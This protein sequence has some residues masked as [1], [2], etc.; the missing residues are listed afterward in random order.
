MGKY[1][2]LISDKFDAH[3]IERLKKE[4]KLFEII[5]ENGHNRE[6]F[7]Q[8]LPKA[9]GLIV[10]SATKV[11]TLALEV[12][13]NLK[14]IIRAGVGVDNID[15]VAAS[16]KGIIVE[17]APGGNSIS[18]AEQALALLFSCARHIPRADASIKAG[19]WEKNKF[20]GI[21]ITGKTLGIV[22]LGRIGKEVLNRALGLKM[23][24]VGFDPFIPQEKLAH[25]QIELVS[26]ERLLE[27][28]DFITVHTP[29]TDTTKD[30]INKKNL[31]ILKKGVIL[32]NAA[33]G[34]IYN[35][36]ALVEGLEKKII[37]AV[38]L[39]VFIEEP[40]PE[41]SKLRKFENCVMTPHLGASTE[42][43]EYAVAMETVDAMT[44]YFKNGVARNSLNFPTIDSESMEFL[45][46]Y[47]EGGI[48]IGKFLGNLVQDISNIQIN[49]FGEITQFRTEAVTIALQYGVLSVAM[50]DE[51]NLVNASLLAQSRGIQTQIS[52]NSAAKGFSCYVQI[53]LNNTRGQN[54]E[55]KYTVM[56]NQALIFSLF[57]LA[58]EFKPEGKL[59]VVQNKDTPGVIGV[60]GT[61]LG[62]KNINIAHL[63]LS[64][65]NKGGVAHSIISTDELL[66]ADG[67]EEM[68]SLPNII[69]VHQIELL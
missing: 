58:I 4:V 39:D 46:P 59:L 67:I 32:I 3:G 29:L 35:E 19:L 62:K 56:Q 16:Q 17:N 43:A 28:S 1:V 64:R 49:Y 7:L 37:A 55:L 15:V 2:I 66:D 44:D 45:K 24:V 26:K 23:K 48:H 52:Q 34:G 8:H 47:F 13:K 12:A 68:R 40:L 6:Q 42:D 41:N 5:Y 65:G 10:R 53:L 63:E 51:V 18:T 50:G 33:R 21:E 60:I 69:D 30:F 36:E 38:G 54:I 22:G 61:F 20:K 11:D 25:L 14:I 27:V 31:D 57:N 9:H